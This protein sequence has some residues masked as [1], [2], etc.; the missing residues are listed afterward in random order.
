[1]VNEKWG[2]QDVCRVAQEITRCMVG[3]FAYKRIMLES[4]M[5]E[6]QACLTMVSSTQ[7]INSII[8]GD[9]AMTMSQALLSL[10]QKIVKA[11]REKKSLRKNERKDLLAFLGEEL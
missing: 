5:R 1:M 4:G 9:A 8:V 7:E 11:V 6:W 2:I 10:Q 3:E